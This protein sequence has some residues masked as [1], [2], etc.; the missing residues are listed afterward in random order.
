MDFGNPNWPAFQQAT[1][2]KAFRLECKDT[3]VVRNVG[4][5]PPSCKRLEFRCLDLQLVSLADVMGNGF[6]LEVERCLDGDR[7]WVL[8]RC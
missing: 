8:T 2:L 3:I 4:V 1:S 7:T 6:R 5:L